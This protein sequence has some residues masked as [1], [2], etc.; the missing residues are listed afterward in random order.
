MSNPYPKLVVKIKAYDPVKLVGTLSPD[1]DI[2]NIIKQLESKTVYVPDVSGTFKN[3]DLITLYGKAAVRL[4]NLVSQLDYIEVLSYGQEG[5]SGISML[6]NTDYFDYRQNQTDSEV[7]NLLK[8]FESFGK[9]V[10]LF[11]DISA[12]GFSSG[13]SDAAYLIVPEQENGSLA[14]DLSEL[15]KS[16]IRDFVSNGNTVIMFAPGNNSITFPNNVFGFSL[17]YDDGN[18]SDLNVPDASGTSF[19]SGPSNLQSFSATH[20]IITST[21]P[22]GSK[23][24]YTF[25]GGDY[26]TVVQIPYNRGKIIIMGW[27]WFNAAPYGSYDGGWLQVLELAVS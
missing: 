14:P 8:S 2:A 23:S 17:D 13:L 15:A 7:W 1:E 12:S 6:S 5:V 27:D 18:N 11:S 9:T 26:A 10:T 21:L 4:Y 24:I 20:S 16:E 3:G 22:V 25:N 19:A